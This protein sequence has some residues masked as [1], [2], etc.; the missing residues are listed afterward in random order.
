MPRKFGWVVAL[1]SAVAAVG[2][3]SASGQVTDA[4]AGLGR[5][6]T[7]SIHARQALPTPPSRPRA[8]MTASSRPPPAYPRRISFA[9]GTGSRGFA[10]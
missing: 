8:S 3:A 2:S 5:L 1:V 7:S 10:R 4:G 9:G 6:S